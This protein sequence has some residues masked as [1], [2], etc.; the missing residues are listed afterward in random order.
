MQRFGEDVSEK[1]DYA[2]GSFSVEQHIRGKWACQTCETLVQEPV[3][4]H[5]IDKGIPTTNLL[6]QVLISKYADHQPLY[7]QQQIY[8]RAGVELP[9]STL[10]G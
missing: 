2:P 9:R 7:R 10:S 3:A 1:L 5:I 8:A 4:A 6:A